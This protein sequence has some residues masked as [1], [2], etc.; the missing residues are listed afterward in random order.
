MNTHTFTLKEIF[1]SAWDKAVEHAWYLLCVFLGAAVIMG[2]VTP[3]PIIGA[4]VGVFLGVA[5]ITIALVIVSGATPTFADLLKSFKNYKI[6]WHYLLASLLYGLIVL[7]GLI[8][9]ILPGIYL[10]VRLQFYKFLV[11]EHEDMGV[12]DSL[13]Q[14]LNMS[15]GHFW[16]LFAFVVIVIIINIAGALAFGV[17][18]LVTVPVSVLASTLVYKKLHGQRHPEHV[19]PE[20]PV[21]P[22]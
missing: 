7:V 11:V 18:L 10:A 2:A 14:S 21:L 5:I 8:A 22:L 17:G 1:N 15:R 3:I 13:K 9:L 20:A 19:H 4:I 12:V 16:K 6:V